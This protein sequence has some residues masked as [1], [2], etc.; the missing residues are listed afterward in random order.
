VQLGSNY[1][2]GTPKLAIE[3]AKI[4]T[5]EQDWPL[6]EMRWRAFLRNFLSS[7]R[8]EHFVALSNA[9]RK[10]GRFAE[11]EVA[12]NEGRATIKGSAL[13]EI[14][15]A[16]I[17]TN[18][19]D[20][21]EASVR[22][23]SVLELRNIDRSE[24]VIRLGLVYRMQGASE[25]ARLC[26][27]SL[28]TPIP[29][30]EGYGPIERVLDHRGSSVNY[31]ARVGSLCVH[32]HLFHL[33]MLELFAD[34]LR[35][36]PQ[37]FSLAVSV[38]FGTD[39]EYWKTA[40]SDAVP[41]AQNVVVLPVANRG[42]DVMPWTCQFREIVLAHEIFLHVHTKVSGGSKG[43]LWSEFLLNNT[44]GSASVI[45]NILGMFEDD[46]LGLV[47]PPYHRSLKAQPNWGKNWV[48]C[49]AL[50][51]RLFNEPLPE[52]CPDYPA[53]SFFW[54]RSRYLKPILD[55]SLSEAD[56]PA[57]AGQYDG[58][59][60]HAIERILGTLDI[61]TGLNKKCIEVSA[62]MLPAVVEA[63]G[64]ADLRR[65]KAPMESEAVDKI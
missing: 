16:E 63:V 54:A 56:F 35:L 14:E 37:K 24:I 26:F 25:E 5:A 32:L 13:L 48:A 20:W 7:A 8:P 31:P 19:H 3:N 65:R 27:N 6:A 17:A 57:E 49:D 22:W 61:Q 46:K 62:H 18:S 42:R 55:L 52:A 50:Y 2:P 11:A 10:Q 47:Y 45:E 51:R 23:R 59:L 9:C 40:I 53:G 39:S 34:R 64:A 58:T 1:H 29:S 15:W 36:V 21:S 41:N 30:F 38:P 12:I 4:A 44:L 33:A 43:L 60:A 28:P